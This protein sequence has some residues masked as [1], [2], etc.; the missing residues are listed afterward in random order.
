MRPRL[1]LAGREDERQG[2]GCKEE[3]GGFGK[4][5][6]WRSRIL[7]CT[8]SGRGLI[9]M[10]INITIGGGCIAMMTDHCIHLWE[11]KIN[12]HTHKPLN[13]M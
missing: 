5:D 10:I 7:S 13:V 1:V 11:E 4:T 3:G 8:Y 9:I 12:K 6:K 2:F